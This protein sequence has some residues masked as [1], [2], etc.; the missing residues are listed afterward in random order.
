MWRRRTNRGTQFAQACA[1]EMHFD[2]SEEPFYARICKENATLQNL[3]ARSVRACAVEMHMDTSQ[4]PFCARISQE[5]ARPGPRH[6]FCASV[7]NRNAHGHL[8]RAILCGN[9]QVKGRGPRWIPRPWPRRGAQLKCTWTCH[10]G[11]FKAIFYK[12][13]QKK[14]REPR[15]GTSIKHRPLPLPQEPLSVDTPFA[16]KWWLPIVALV[17]QR[18]TIIFSAITN[19]VAHHFL[20]ASGHPANGAGQKPF[21][22]HDNGGKTICQNNSEPFGWIKWLDGC[23]MNIPGWNMIID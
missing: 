14:S 13:L 10:K 4:K 3:H 11:N 5:K 6:L 21:R 19:P 22:S 20:S 9:L 16:E 1:V 2:I 18:L 8:T 23:I 7:R 17:Y 15:V 12:N